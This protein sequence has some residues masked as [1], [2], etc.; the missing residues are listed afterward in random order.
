MLIVGA[1]GGVGSFLTQYVVRAGAKVIAVIRSSERDRI[2]GYGAVETIDVSSP[3]ADTVR[4][5]HPEG[6]D[7]VID[8]ASDAPAFAGLAGLVRRGGTA[9]TTR[10]VA[11][12]KTLGTAG[13]TGVNFQVKTSADVLQRL[14]DAVA[15]GLIV[16]PPITRIALADAPV[17]LNRI[18]GGQPEGKTVITP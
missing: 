2:R 7:V 5:A 10:Y 3:V 4:R 16:A 1:A 8:V 13:V 12:V 18:G 11:D 6:V 14:A 17:A 15:S 9:L